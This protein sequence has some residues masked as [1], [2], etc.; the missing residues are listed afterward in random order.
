MI[1]IFL[2]NI[3]LN[4]TFLPGQPGVVAMGTIRVRLVGHYVSDCKGHSLGYMKKVSN[5]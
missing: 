2:H 3:P 5:V 4:S 1:K